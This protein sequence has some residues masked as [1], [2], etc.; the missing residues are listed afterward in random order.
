MTI[1]KR[2][3][4]FAVALLLLVLGLSLLVERSA[5]R[6]R[7]FTGTVREWRAGESITIVTEQTGL[8]GFTARLRNTR[9]EGQR[10]QIA[11]GTNVTIWYRMVGE[12]RP[13]ADKVRINPTPSF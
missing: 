2:S 9:F 13:V 1:S 6:Q 10:D 5:R 3:R 4:R 12:S 7:T 8:P 11:A